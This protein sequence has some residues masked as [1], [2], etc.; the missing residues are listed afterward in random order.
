MNIFC[1]GLLCLILNPWTDGLINKRTNLHEIRTHMHTQDR[2]TIGALRGINTIVQHDQRL[3]CMPF[4]TIQWIRLLKPYHKSTRARPTKPKRI[5]QTGFNRSRLI[6]I[7]REGHK[8]DTN[9]IF[10]TCNIQLIKF[11]EVVTE[12]WLSNKQEHWK[13]TTILNRD[14]F[15]QLTADR[16]SGKPEE[17]LHLY[18][19][20]NTR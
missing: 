19:S 7:K 2:V 6:T 1:E 16:T 3:R 20:L 11:R 17:A 15:N 8:P 10:S 18:I 4:G 5:K 9:M 14:G 13:D 12:T